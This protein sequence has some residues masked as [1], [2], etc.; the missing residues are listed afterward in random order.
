M[1]E[2]VVLPVA[3]KGTRLLPATKSVPK[4]LLPVY[5]TPL[6]QFALDEAVAA[7][8]RKIVLVSH[9][10]KSAL[11]EYFS[12]E[13]QLLEDLDDAGKD[14]IAS[15]VRRAS[16]PSNVEITFVFQDEPLGLGHAV[17]CAREAVEGSEFGVVLPDDLLSSGQC[18]RRMASV[19]APSGARSLVAAMRVPDEQVSKY[20]IFRTRSAA[21]PTTPCDGMVEKPALQDAPSRLAAIG[22]YILPAAIFDSLAA[23]APGSGGEIQL[24][25]AIDTLGGL[26]AFEIDERR[27]DCGSKEGLFEA[28]VDIRKTR[29]RF[30]RI[31]A[32]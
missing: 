32:E 31:A 1:I 7:G 30:D 17:L 29:H 14:D 11:E 20:G 6:L 12:R 3:G 8:A 10:E 16:V 5:D 13:R 18:L 4:E 22:R 28:T 21:G 15:D 27:Y 19:Y 23:Q 9:R 26:H 24:T 25:D 2:T